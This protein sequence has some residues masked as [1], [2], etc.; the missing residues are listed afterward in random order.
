REISASPIG[1]KERE[2]CEGLFLLREPSPH[3][4]LSERERQVI[5]I[6]KDKPH[7]LIEIA[8]RIGMDVNFLDMEA[9]VSQGILGTVGF[10][11]TDILHLTGDCDLGSAEGAG[12]AAELIARHWHKPLA[13]LL[14]ILKRVV[15]EKLCRVIL[16]SVFTYD[17]IDIDFFSDEKVAEFFF[18]NA[19]WDKK[20]ELFASSFSLQSPLIG[21][22]APT[23]SWLPLAGEKLNTPTL[24][25]QY[26]HV[27]NA[28]G[29][30]AGKVMTIQRVLV[31]NY[32]TEGVFIHGPWGNIKFKPE[33]FQPGATEHLR[34]MEQAI[35]YAKEEGE[36]YLRADME[37]QGITD[38]DIIIE[39]SHSRVGG[40]SDLEGFIL[41]LSTK[42]DII[43]IGRPRRLVEKTEQKSLLGKFWGVDKSPDY[44]KAPY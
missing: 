7:T 29:A 3:M 19:V 14:P 27:A 16:D 15:A 33:E 4:D 38:Y 6:V 8:H 44:T 42:I 35:A 26:H 37:K 31:Q 24:F 40:K 21:I 13:D 17:K 20:R 32:D 11:P 9:L 36:K 34:I 10:T 2:H 18:Q 28:V 23:Q 25:P 43:A 30:A 1:I 41:H 12:F 5:D 22:G 39:E